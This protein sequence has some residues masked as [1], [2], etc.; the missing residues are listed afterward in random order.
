MNGYLVHIELLS[1]YLDRRSGQELCNV[2]HSH[3]EVDTQLQ[4]DVGKI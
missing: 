4:N 1:C 2:L 3:K